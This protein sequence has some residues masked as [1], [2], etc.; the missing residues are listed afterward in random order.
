MSP[1]SAAMVNP[2]IQPIPGGHQQRDV[3]M[4]GAGA[5]QPALDLTNP[6]LEIVDQLKARPNV[7]KPGLGKIQL[8]EKSAAATPNRSAIGT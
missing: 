3:A 1:I 8:G 4:I 6:P 2:V 5:A 7:T